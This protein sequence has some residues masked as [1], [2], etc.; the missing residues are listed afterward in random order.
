MK[1]EPCWRRWRKPRPGLPRGLMASEEEEQI[2][3]NK[4]RVGPVPGDCYESLVEVVFAACIYH[5]DHTELNSVRARC[6]F[7]VPDSC[8][9]AS[10]F[11]NSVIH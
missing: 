6:C 5:A 10:V 3:T 9:A 7:S 11:F 4:E 8:T 2:A 1:C